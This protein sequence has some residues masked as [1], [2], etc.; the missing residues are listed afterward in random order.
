MSSETESTAAVAP[1]RF[2]RL[3]ISTLD[4]VDMGRPEHIRSSDAQPRRA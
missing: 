2:V 3:R 1:K 4:S